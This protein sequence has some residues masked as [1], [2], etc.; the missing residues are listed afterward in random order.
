MDFME[1]VNKRR[2]GIGYPKEDEALQ[3]DEALP[4]QVPVTVEDKLRTGRW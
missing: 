4:E 2:I 1:V 3:E